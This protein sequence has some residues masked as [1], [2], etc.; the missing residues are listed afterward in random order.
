MCKVEIYANIILH[1]GREKPKSC[2]NEVNV[3]WVI[4]HRRHLIDDYKLHRCVISHD[5]NGDV[6]Y[7]PENILLEFLS[8]R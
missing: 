8:A 6:K 1:H 7:Y 3:L 5:I 4:E 2:K